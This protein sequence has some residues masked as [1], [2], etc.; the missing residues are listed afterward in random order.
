MQGKRNRLVYKRTP[1]TLL[2]TIIVCC[3]CVDRYN[4]I[5]PKLRSYFFLDIIEITIKTTQCSVK[6]QYSYMPLYAIYCEP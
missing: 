2:I 4:F 5:F 1:E 6:L 3:K